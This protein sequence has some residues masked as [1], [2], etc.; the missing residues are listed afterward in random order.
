MWFCFVVAMVF[1]TLTS[2][3]LHG[4]EWVQFIT[5]VAI[6]ISFLIFIL[7]KQ[8]LKKYQ[9]SKK[10]WL[11]IAGLIAFILIDTCWHRIF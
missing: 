10:D 11:I 1:F 8:F 2:T 5:C 9:V 4:Y 6:G 7:Q 3:K